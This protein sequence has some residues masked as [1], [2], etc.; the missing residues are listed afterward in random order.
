MILGARFRDCYGTPREV[1]EVVGNY[2]DIVSFNCYTLIPPLEFLA[3]SY[4]INQ[5]PI[6][7]SEFSFKA[8]DSGLPNLIGP[9][10][11]FKSQ[12]ERALW[13]EKYVSHS[14]SSPFIV[15]HIWYKYDDDP[16]RKMAE[17]S[18]FGLVNNKNLPY[19]LFTEKV[20]EINRKVYWM[21][22]KKSPAR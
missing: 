20:K 15:G 9:G 13:Y 5:K 16:P 14:L 17:N 4:K 1:L 22:E 6:L 8:E 21:A 12:R 18:N 2:M 11:T 19:D 7:I 3:E 10:Y